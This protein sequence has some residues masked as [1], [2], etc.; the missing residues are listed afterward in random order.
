MP[1]WLHVNIYFKSCPKTMAEMAGQA[2]PETKPKGFYKRLILYLKNVVG[3]LSPQLI[4]RYFYFFEPQPHLFLALEMRNK[5]KINLI[6]KMI[7]QINKPSFI[8]SAIIEP[9]NDEDNG[10]AAI[11]FFHAA[12]KFSFFRISKQYKPIY[13][14]N[15]ETKMIH[16]FCN[17]LFVNHKNEINFYLNRLKPFI[18]RRKN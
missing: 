14:N 12:T 13:T 17:Q 6:K 5:N 9:S 1:Q 15:N 8:E 7:K 4:N 11:D 3:A 16:C 18:K 2:L 10:N